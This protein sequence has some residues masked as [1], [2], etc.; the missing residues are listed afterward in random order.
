MNYVTC[1][2]NVLKIVKRVSTTC[3]KLSIVSCSESPQGHAPKVVTP[4][5]ELPTIQV[6]DEVDAEG[7][8]F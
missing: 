2:D 6:E 5:E 3:L 4:E 7:I 8:T 1:A